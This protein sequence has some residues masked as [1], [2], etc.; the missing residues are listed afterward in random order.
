MSFK[1]VAL[2]AAKSAGKI[3]KSDF[4]NIDFVKNKGKHDIVSASDYKSENV[5]LNILKSTFPDHTI[6]T[7]ESG[8]QNRP[9]DYCWYVD[10]L[11][12]TANFVAG[13]PYFSV[14]IALSYRGEII[15]GVVFNP[16]L[17]ELYRAEKGKGAFLNNKSI[18][19][20]KK[21][22]LEDAFLSSAHSSN[23][24][25]LKEALR[26][27]GK[28]SLNSRKLLISFSPAL[29]LCNIARGRLDGLVDIGTTPEDHAAG[30]IIVTEAGG[31]VQNYKSAS[32]DVNKKGII[33]SNGFLH[34]KIL[35]IIK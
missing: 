29:N 31:K 23:E 18:M 30:N 1:Y 4:N 6:V 12:G 3:L 27:I 10:P 14:S 15:L 5:I 2:K 9:S 33:A 13:I 17:N 28:L 16:I 8:K 25:N 34:T 21:K 24:N 32:W 19:V 26:I 7:E 20:S 35:E 11:D 22:D